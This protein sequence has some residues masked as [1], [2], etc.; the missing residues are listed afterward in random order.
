MSNIGGEGEHRGLIPRT[1]EH[2]FSEVIVRVVLLGFFWAWFN[3][4]TR[5]KLWNEFVY[6][7]LADQTN[8]LQTEHPEDGA[9]QITLAYMQVSPLRSLASYS[10][11]F[12][13]YSLNSYFDDCPSDLQRQGIRF[14]G[15]F[16]PCGIYPKFVSL[17][18]CVPT[19]GAGDER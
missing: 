15:G 16:K 19:Q 2:V 7:L 1:L 3:Y 4:Y 8:R 13:Q 9:F 18:F 10:L 17:N 6:F 14:V 5:G 11:C 12:R